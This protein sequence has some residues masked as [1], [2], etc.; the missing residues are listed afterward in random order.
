MRQLYQVQVG[1]SRQRFDQTG[2]V[3]VFFNGPRGLQVAVQRVVLHQQLARHGCEAVVLLFPLLF[4]LV[5]LLQRANAH[6]LRFQ[7]HALVV[8][9][10][11]T[12][13]R[14]RGVVV[15][16]LQPA[17][18]IALLIFGFEV[19][20]LALQVVVL[21]QGKVERVQLN[22]LLDVSIGMLSGFF[23]YAEGLYQARGVAFHRMDR[24]ELPGDGTDRFAKILFFQDLVGDEIT[25]AA[26][27]FVG[28]E[29]GKGPRRRGGFLFGNAVLLAAQGGVE[30]TQVGF[31]GVVFVYLAFAELADQQ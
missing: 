9:L 27:R 4:Q 10:L 31:L 30:A 15:I 18:K 28:H 2:I 14:Q 25:D 24:L 12:L 17:L 7:L 20:A 11:Q 5:F 21:G 22:P 8:C 23:Q 19:F 1:D 29:T 13:F 16:F 6:S 3:Q 26:H